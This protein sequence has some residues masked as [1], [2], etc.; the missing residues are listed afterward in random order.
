LERC[1]TLQKLRKFGKRAQFGENRVK[2][3]IAEM[4]SFDDVRCTKVFR[5]TSIKTDK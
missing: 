1:R 5:T 2:C 3:N 4:R